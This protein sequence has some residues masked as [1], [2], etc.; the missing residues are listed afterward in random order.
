MLPV[1]LGIPSRSGTHLLDQICGFSNVAPFSN[2]CILFTQIRRRKW[3]QPN[4]EQALTWSTHYGRA[5]R[6]RHSLRVRGITRVC[7]PKFALILFS[8][9]RDVGRSHSFMSL[10]DGSAHHIITR[11]PDFTRPST[12]IFGGPDADRNFH[13]AAFAPYLAGLSILKLLTI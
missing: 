2:A 11:L 7:S 1:L 4:T 5:C 8:R 9:P 12:S 3:T 6:R 13:I 10:P